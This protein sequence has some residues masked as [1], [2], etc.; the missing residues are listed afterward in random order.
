M[1]FV[2]L[3]DN[4]IAVPEEAA[5]QSKSGILL[6]A[7]TSREQP[8]IAKVSSVGPKVANIKVGDRFLFKAFAAT[9]LKVGDKDYIAIS[10]EFVI[11]KITE[12]K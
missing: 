3:F 7:G 9:E 5:K 1:I 10:E 6:A 11:A 4:I 2:P 12:S 8:R